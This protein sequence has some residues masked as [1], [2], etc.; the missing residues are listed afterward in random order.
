MVERRL[1]KPKVAGSNPVFRSK[2]TPP[3]PQTAA[4]RPRS[5]LF[6]L[7][8]RSGKRGSPQDLLL[9]PVEG[10]GG[11][12]KARNTRADFDPEGREISASSNPVFRSIKFPK[13]YRPQHPSRKPPSQTSQTRIRF[14]PPSK[15]VHFPRDITPPSEGEFP[16]HVHQSICS[17]VLPPFCLSTPP[18]GEQ[19][20]KEIYSPSKGGT[21]TKPPTPN[22]SLLSAGFRTFAALWQ[23]IISKEDTTNTWNGR[24]QPRKRSGQPGRSGSTPIGSIWQKQPPSP[25]TVQNLK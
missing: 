5:F 8:H 17:G 2:E 3:E 21:A 25:K 20:H 10:R 11:Y 4:P 13:D 12:K 9:P 15:G 24:P 18:Q 19:K 22:I 7:T 14:P 23:T 6:H 16:Y 1:P